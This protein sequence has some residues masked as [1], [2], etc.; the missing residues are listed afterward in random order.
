MKGVFGTMLI[1]VTNPKRINLYDMRTA[2]EKSGI[3]ISRLC[4][5]TYRSLRNWEKGDALPNIV[6]VYDLLQIYGHSYDELD[7]TPFY[8]GQ[9]RDEINKRLEAAAMKRTPANNPPKTVTFEDMRQQSGYSGAAV[10]ELCNVSYRT[11]RNW[12]KGKS[13][14]NVINADDL[15]HLYGYSFYE[16]DMVPFFTI[17]EER[18][19][20]KKERYALTDHQLRDRR[21]RFEQRLEIQTNTPK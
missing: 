17:F 12:E 11:I 1:D 16:L 21:R 3:T 10:A 19:R 9:N 8:K 20:K 2:S 6:N 14:P 15:L 13:I 5:T 4:G 7:F 18:T